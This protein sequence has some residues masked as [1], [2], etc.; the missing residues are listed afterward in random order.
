MKN[1]FLSD[2][3]LANLLPKTFSSFNLAGGMPDFQH[4]VESL[5][6]SFRSPGRF[7]PWAAGKN[8]GLLLGNI[9][10]TFWFV[11][12]SLLPPAN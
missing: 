3:S 4:R 1:E 5:Q 6:K 7:V 9:L 8:K 12:D 2:M 11:F 10:G